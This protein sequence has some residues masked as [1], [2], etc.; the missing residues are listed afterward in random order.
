MNGDRWTMVLGFG[1]ALIVL[2]IL[3]WL[4]G[5][6]ET[7][8][9]L[10]R[11]DLALV[12]AAT[13]LS[14]L[15]LVGWGMSLHTVLRAMDAPISIPQAVLVFTAAMFSNNVTPFGQAGGEPVS[16]YLI[17]EAADS[18]YE[19]GLAAIASVDTLHFVPSIAL[20]LTGLS[21]LLLR[22]VALGR[23]LYFALASIATLVTAFVVTA[24]LGYRYRHEIEGAIARGLAPVLRGL[25]RLVPWKDP[26]ST[27]DIAA[28]VSGFFTAIDRIA[29]DRRAIVLA[30]SYSALGWTS[31]SA[32]LWVSVYAVGAEVPFALALFVVPIGSIAGVTPLPGG[33]GAIE[34]AFVGML[35][36][37]GIPRSAAVAAVFIH[38]IASYW[39]PTFVGGGVAA[40]LGARRGRRVRE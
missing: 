36:I 23:H 1:V 21:V 3:V 8:G 31:L 40:V 10:R 6:D 29:A 20:A 17:A 30:S 16:A 12:A 2:A 11:A 33:A 37:G 27:E 35:L 34:S 18:D 4:A 13:G 7:I 25:F 19:T 15:W 32:A 39:L 26:P 22:A 9:Q 24:V 38:R 14:T 28:G 5:A